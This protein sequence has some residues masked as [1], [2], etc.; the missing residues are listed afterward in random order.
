[1]SIEAYKIPLIEFHRQLSFLILE[2]KQ[3]IL[4]AYDTKN[5]LTNIS[6]LQNIERRIQWYRDRIDDVEPNAPFMPG[7]K[8]DFEEL[9]AEI[10]N[11]KL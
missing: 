3:E 2:K 5:R 10:E 8:K 11:V 7:F 1:M 9:K 6:I 4:D